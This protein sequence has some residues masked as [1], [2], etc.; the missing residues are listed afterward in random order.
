MVRQKRT[1]ADL[2]VAAPPPATKKARTTAGATAGPSTTYPIEPA[3]AP[4]AKRSRK[5][6][7]AG[8]AEDAPAPEK[9]LARFKSSCPQNISER[10]GRVMSQ[11]FFMVDRAREVGQLKEEFKV[12]GSTGNIYTVTIQHLPSCDCPDARKGNHCKHI[13]FVFLKVLQVPQSWGHWYQKALLTTELQEIFSRAPMAPNAVANP[14]VRAAY[15]AAVG[16][17]L[18]SNPTGGS[19][20]KAAAEPEQ[21]KRMP[22]EDDDCPICYDGMHNV[23]ETQLVFCETCGNAVHKECFGQ[24]QNTSLTQNKPL[25]CIYCRSKWPQPSGGASGSGAG[26]R[27]AVNEGYVNLAGVAGVDSVRDTTTYYDGP[28][29]GQSYYGGYGRYGYRGRYGYDFEYEDDDY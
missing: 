23:P 8:D 2:D 16:K 5:K 29:R 19:S 12:L 15:A 17:P 21:K 25:T 20:S 18:S 13:L 4:K 11:R 22:G 6:A 7:A 24:W 27:A 28:R 14:R 10:V 26:G 9:R 1:L 3:P